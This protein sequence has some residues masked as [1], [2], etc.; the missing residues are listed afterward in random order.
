M[1]RLVTIQRIS[2]IQPIEGADRIETAVVLGWKC[3][4][5]K[6]DFAVG[7][8]C[9]Y[10]E[11]DSFL[12]VGSI[13][14]SMDFLRNNSY[15][16]TSFQGEGY[17]I[18]TQKLRGQVSQGLLLPLSSVKA[19][20]TTFVK[21]IPEELYE[22][23]DVTEIFGVVKYDPPEVNT[24]VGTTKGSR[25][26]GIP[27]TDETRVQSIPEVIKELYGKPYYITTKMDGTS[28]T[29]YW[30]DGKFGICGRND[31]YVL[32]DICMF[33]RYAKKYCVEEKM[34]RKGRNLALQGE[35][36]GPGIQKN[37]LC[38]KEFHWYIFNA[39]D[40]DAQEYLDFEDM[41]TL[42]EELSLEMVPLEEIG[43][44]FQYATIEELLIRANGNYQSGKPKEGIVIRTLTESKSKALGNGRFSFKVLNNQFLLK[45]N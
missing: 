16:K 33:N 21:E 11:V 6:G 29:M 26:Y 37:R 22:G 18:R 24:G 13:F 41:R 36:C 8:L 39:F 42:V 17:R 32:D 12:P 34:N 7:D 2:D 43:D 27:K 38:L 40:L 25:P 15:K 10:F 5:T 19:V 45:Q 28:V 1:R 23:D 44:K 30:N 14:D 31:E 35:F 9:V 3:V 20:G 4:I